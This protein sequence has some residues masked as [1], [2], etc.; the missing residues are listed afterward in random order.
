MRADISKIVMFLF[1][2]LQLYWDKPIKQNP[3]GCLGPAYHIPSQASLAAQMVQFNRFVHVFFCVRSKEERGFS[4][5]FFVLS[6]L[7]HE[8]SN[9]WQGGT[10]RFY[11]QN[12]IP[13][14][15]VG[16]TAT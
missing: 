7:L 14:V 6:L 12:W 5:V 11:I 10:K 16:R 8:E 13:L 4:C 15:L 1:T 3:V 9:P 2:E